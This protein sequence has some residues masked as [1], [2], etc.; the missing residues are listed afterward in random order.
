MKSKSILKMFLALLLAVVAT[1]GISAVAYAGDPP[2]LDVDIGIVG[3]DP[4]VGIDI[5]GDN[6]NVTLTVG[7]D[8]N[9]YINKPAAGSTA[10]A[11]PAP[12]MG[13]NHETKTWLKGLTSGLNLTADGLAKI[14]LV[15]NEQGNI[16]Q[17]NA[18]KLEG[19]GAGISR[20][21]SELLDLEGQTA[22]TFAMTQGQVTALEQSLRAAKTQYAMMMGILLAIILAL[23]ATLGWIVYRLRRAATGE[24]VPAGIPVTNS[25]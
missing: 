9:I 11:G 18:T 15:T 24:A 13:I 5:W 4:D 17:G 7:P 8:G 10:G 6:A 21:S 22:E 3:D 2:G 19:Q 23:A 14:I 20:L 12:P 16:I 25:R 1:L